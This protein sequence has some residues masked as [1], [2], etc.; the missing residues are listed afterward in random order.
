MNNV[1][2]CTIMMFKN[3]ISK[4]FC[5]QI[6]KKGVIKYQN[7]RAKR[8]RKQMRK[9]ILLAFCGYAGQKKYWKKKTRPPFRLRSGK[10]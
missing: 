10:I 4:E 6:D 7:V 8:A 1:L 9:C 5:Q 2:S 3:N